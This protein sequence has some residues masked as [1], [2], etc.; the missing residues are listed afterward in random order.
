MTTKVSIVRAQSNACI[1]CDNEHCLDSVTPRNP[2]LTCSRLCV[3]PQRP[4]VLQ[5]LPD[6]R[7]GDARCLASETSPCRP[8]DGVREVRL[9][10]AVISFAPVPATNQ[11][12]E[13]GDDLG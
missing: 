6:V 7:T 11:L 9:L 12:L 8:V 13:H 3:R 2:H 1:F 5:R 10:V 4:S